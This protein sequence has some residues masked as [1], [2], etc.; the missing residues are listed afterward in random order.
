M[1]LLSDE[2]F[3]NTNKLILSKDKYS[4]SEYVLL[5]SLNV[6]IYWSI[7]STFPEAR[8]IKMNK[9]GK[10]PSITELIFPHQWKKIKKIYIYMYK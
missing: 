7:P 9:I 2:N 6:F 5:F 8:D 10:V 1:V 4:I 3:K